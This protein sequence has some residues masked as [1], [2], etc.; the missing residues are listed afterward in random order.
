[1]GVLVSLYFGLARS[2]VA[3]AVVKTSVYR[4][5]VVQERASPARHGGYR[6]RRDV[7]QVVAASIGAESGCAAECY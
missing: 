5:R 7:W 2:G 6:M 1:M 4:A 3:P